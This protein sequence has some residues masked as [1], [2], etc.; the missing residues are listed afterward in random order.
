M[1]IIFHII[2]SPILIISHGDK[3]IPVVPIYFW[4]LRGTP[5]LIIKLFKCTRAAFGLWSGAVFCHCL[6]VVAC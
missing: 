3:E 4:P 1:S 5:S 6:K 2:R